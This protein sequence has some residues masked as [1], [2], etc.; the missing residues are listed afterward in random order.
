MLQNTVVMR[1]QPKTR[2]GMRR[3]ASKNLAP[4]LLSILVSI[5]FT[6]LPRMDDSNVNAHARAESS[7]DAS[8]RLRRDLSMQDPSD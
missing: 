2:C 6:K 3:Q 8:R 7:I 4:L 5:A 1:W